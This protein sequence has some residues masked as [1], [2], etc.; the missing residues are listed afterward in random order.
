[1]KDLLMRAKHLFV[2]ARAGRVQL[3]VP[4]GARH[5]P[6]VGLKPSPPPAAPCF[7]RRGFG[8]DGHGALSLRHA[9]GRLRAAVGR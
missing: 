5:P 1:M 8:G 2:G 7:G 9:R 6:G 3:L 4:P